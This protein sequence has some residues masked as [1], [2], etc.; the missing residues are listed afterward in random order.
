MPPPEHL[1]CYVRFFFNSPIEPFDSDGIRQLLK[2]YG[3]TRRPLLKSVFRGCSRPPG[4]GFEQTEVI[5]NPRQLIHHQ[6]ATFG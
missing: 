4:L 6:A 3:Q 5:F 2:S 1:Y